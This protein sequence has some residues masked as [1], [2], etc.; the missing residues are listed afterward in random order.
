MTNAPS[1]IMY[2]FPPDVM[3]D[4]LEGIIPAVLRL[5][6]QEH[7]KTKQITVAQL[8][9]KIDNFPYGNYNKASRPLPQ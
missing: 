7:V 5:V 8:N 1:P 3:H 6:L 9:Y 4:F 2:L